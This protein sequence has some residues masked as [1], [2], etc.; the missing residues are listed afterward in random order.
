MS[1]E[2]SYPSCNINLSLMGSLKKQ[3]IP[4]QILHILKLFLLEL[5]KSV[6]YNTVVGIVIIMVIIIIRIQISSCWFLSA[7]LLLARLSTKHF[8]VI[9]TLNPNSNSVLSGHRR[10]TLVFPVNSL[11]SEVNSLCPQHLAQ[12]WMCIRYALVDVELTWTLAYHLA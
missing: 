3:I 5:K 10:A 12:G 7:S 9:N 6:N 1:G 8:T 2:R 4:K 11:K